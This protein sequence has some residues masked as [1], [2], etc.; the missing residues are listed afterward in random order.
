MTMKTLEAAIIDLDGVITQT[1]AQHARA[2]KQ[3][4][5]HYNEQRISGGK[6]AFTPFS[7]EDDY[8]HYIDGIPR[9]DGVRNFL[10]SRNIELP[11]GKREDEPG[12]ETIWGLGNLKNKFFLEVVEREGVDTYSENIEQIKVWR[13][14]GM[15]TAVISSSE[16]CKRILEAC[17]LEDLFDARVDGIVSKER[18]IPGKP[19]PDIFIEAAKAIDVDP[20]HAL[21]VE[22]SL[23][24]V[25]AG[26]RGHFGLVIGVEVSA[27]KEELLEHGADQVVKT[28]HD[29]VLDERSDGN[30]RSLPSALS[31]FEKIA[32][33]C[34][35]KTLCIFL[36]FDGTLAPIVDYYEDATI[37]SE[38][39]S[40]LEKL[41]VVHPLAIISGRGLGDVEQRVG[42]AGIYYAGSH[43]FEIRGPNGFLKEQED[44]KHSLP[45]L[46][47]IQEQVSSKL[48]LIEGS[49][50]ERKKYALAIHYRQVDEALQRDVVDLLSET[51]EGRKHVTIS[52]GKKVIEV[53]PDLDW[54]KGKAVEMILTEFEKERDALFVLYIGDDLTDEDAFQT[55]REGIGIL[56][57]DH[58]E[59]TAAHCHLEDVDEVNEFLTLLTK[60]KA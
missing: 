8:P 9:D 24:G 44:A 11:E 28:L 20:A 55:I 7:I 36:D 34:R 5:D 56:V 30:V 59:R 37:S 45:V 3:L 49:H 6:P 23:A 18:G 29:V 21:V 46:D 19:A 40:I 47:E 12:K 39:R 22:D 14:L 33:Q 41:A 10:H 42:I 35:N 38:T 53:K 60:I 2:W 31:A 52:H 26:K 51:V 32:E 48:K 43:G 13:K 27:S 50:I 4:F 15:K 57:G 17:E 16:N 1:A 58:G 54:H 25:E